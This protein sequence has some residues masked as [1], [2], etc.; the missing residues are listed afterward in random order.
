M[1]KNKSNMYTL[2]ETVQIINELEN[3]MLLFLADL[4]NKHYS[5]NKKR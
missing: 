3:M 2:K 4:L 1:W 5:V